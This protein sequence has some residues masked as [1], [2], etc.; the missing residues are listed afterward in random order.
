MSDRKFKEVLLATIPYGIDIV[1]GKGRVL[2]M[3]KKLLS[4][5]GDKAIGQK[6]WEIYKDDKKQCAK[7]P[8][9]AGIKPGKT[10]TLETD[11]CM[12]GRIISISHTGM[13]HNGDTAILEVFS[14]VTKEREIDKAKSEFLS[15]SSHQLRT[16]LT[17]I[18]WTLEMFSKKENFT[19]RGREYLDN[20]FCCV[21]KLN[22][23]VKLLLSLSRIESG[24][25]QASPEPVELVR[26]I[27]DCLKEYQPLCRKKELAIRFT[28]HPQ[29]LNLKI[30]KTAFDH[31]LRNLIGNAI[32]YSRSNG[33][34]EV[35]L[36]KKNDR[37]ILTVQDNGIGIPREDQGRI[38]GK[39]VRASNAIT[40]KPDST[41]LGLYIAREA[42]KLLGGTIWF[43]SQ[44]GRG[45]KFYVSIPL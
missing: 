14:D 20:I 42:A 9:R 22:D 19:E 29:E 26:F 37:A 3:N 6:C 4:I 36:G 35:C 34:I 7:C 21:K 13:M 2:F 32:D 33:K 10:E 25:F 43:E 5:Y 39:F 44:D 12:N 31:I 30:D 1:D 40:L 15:L 18:Q 16:P 17:G 11:R 24:K 23:L 27:S 41:G 38:F 28:D 45:T 8:L